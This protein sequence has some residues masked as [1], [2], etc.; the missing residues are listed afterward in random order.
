MSLRRWARRRSN[1]IKHTAVFGWIADHTKSR[2]SPL[3]VGLLALA[4]ATVLLCLGR[5]IGLLVVGRLLQGLS[6]AMVWSVGLALL[7]DTVGQKNIGEIMGYI[8]ISLTCAVLAGP[9]LGGVVYE[10]ASYYAVFA[11]CFG[12]IGLDVFL[13]L[14]MIE[15]KVAARWEPRHDDVQDASPG[16]QS[17]RKSLEHRP[18]QGG[19]SNIGQPDVSAESPAGQRD[20][21]EAS[22][23]PG[24]EESSPATETHSR[25]PP[26]LTLL[27]SRRLLAALWCVFVQSL[28]IASFESVRHVGSTT[29]RG[30]V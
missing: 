14:V 22:S 1:T 17:T 6:A 26:V 21:K 23:I 8:T 3:L 29:L 20:T 30:R 28:V 9:L 2:R 24:Q 25:L 13:R 11:M 15:K 10:E 27:K 16:P 7:V 5:T 4:G 18:T 12:L 19:P